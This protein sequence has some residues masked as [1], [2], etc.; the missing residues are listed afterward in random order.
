[1]KK[2]AYLEITQ[3]GT[4]EYLEIV[5][6][7]P[8][9][10][11]AVVIK[12][13]EPVFIKNS[14]IDSVTHGI[15]NGNVDGKPN[16]AYA[17]RLNVENVY[18]KG[19]HPGSGKQQGRA[20][21]VLP[22]KHLRVKHCTL[23]ETAG[24]RAKYFQGD[25]NAGDTVDIQWN[26]V[27]GI[28]GRIAT[29]TD[30]QTKKGSKPMNMQF[31]VIAQSDVPGGQISRNRIYNRY[32]WDVEDTINLQRSGG[33]PGRPF[34]IEENIVFGAWSAQPY[35]REV[36]YT[37]GG[38]IA[39]S[40][41]DGK[42]YI[43]I[44]RNLVLNTMNYGIAVNSTG[45]DILVYSNTVL[46]SGKD[47]GENRMGYCSVGI[48]VLD[49]SK[50]AES[51]FPG[52][53]VNGNISGYVN[54]RQENVRRNDY[55]L[56][57]ALPE[58]VSD[59]ISFDGEITEAVMQ[60][61]YTAKMEGLMNLYPG[62]RWGV[63]EDL[64]DA[65]PGSPTEDPGIPEIP[66]NGDTPV[67]T[68]STG[69]P[70]TVTRGFKSTGASGN[71]IAFKGK[72]LALVGAVISGA[73]Q[74]G[75]R[76][77]GEDSENIWLVNCKATGS[78]VDDITI[79]RDASRKMIRNT[80]VVNCETS[81]AGEEGFDVTAAEGA[82]FV[83]C[84]G[85]TSNIGHLSSKVLYLDCEIDHIKVKACSDI[86][87]VGC[88][89]GELSFEKQGGNDGAGEGP[90]RIWVHNS[91]VGNKDLGQYASSLK[92]WAASTEPIKAMLPAIPAE[93]KEDISA[94]NYG[95]FGPSEE[96][97]PVDEEETPDVP[98]VDPNPGTAEIPYTVIQDTLNQVNN[99]ETVASET[100]ATLVSLQNQII[101]VKNRMK[102]W[103]QP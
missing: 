89:I 42:G 59:N 95:S 68:P 46:H 83:N 27:D 94:W 37:G 67:P 49:T 3:G 88:K 18:F 84:K 72:D 5:N 11:A 7:D 44:Q 9:K 1:M 75:I 50:G 79:H 16:V 28:E 23:Y 14:Y 6:L 54:T 86:Y 57:S 85:P 21:E 34:W 66:G 13:E 2:L 69:K 64:L 78:S 52:A 103:L 51:K 87:F 100:A 40:A 81:G 98:P 15:A 97:P 90:T 48:R 29:E 63:D 80:V 24:I 32:P 8:A 43:V 62:E 25:T 36:K 17:P 92:T 39:D 61:A 99:L 56:S 4:Y 102:T 35:D 41:T 47:G 38:I 77:T 20:I 91:T 55:N 12:T 31:V 60:D 76:V 19:L 53:E 71:G 93:L 82:V 73:G 70:V 22:Y 58:K 30:F 74:N 26:F 65:E 33:G 10:P 45:P 101:A 96:I